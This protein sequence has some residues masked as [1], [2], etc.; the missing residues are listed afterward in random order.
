MKPEF[1]HTDVYTRLGVSALHGI[2]VFAIKPIP[3][4]TN[5]FLNDLVDLVWIEKAA[6]DKAALRPE[7]RKLYHD[8][9]IS[10]GPLIGCPVN[11]HN[12][13]PGWYC[14]EPADGAD[15]NINVDADL[16]FWA[17]SDIAEGE[18]LT[19]RYTDFSKA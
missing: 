13:T 2:G 10:R 3:A 16:N 19:V 15:P 11:F 12:L 14:N 17:T 9:G 4:G 8:F 1:P 7:D 5:V 6:L 18:E